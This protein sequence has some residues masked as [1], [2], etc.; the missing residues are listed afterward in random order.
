MLTR[1]PLLALLLMS[2]ASCSTPAQFSAHEAVPQLTAQNPEMSTLKFATLPQAAPTSDSVENL[3]NSKEA[4][5]LKTHQWKNRLLLVFAPSANSPAYQRQMQ[6]FEGRQADFKERDLLLVELLTQGTSST[7]GKMLD[8]ADVAKLRARF[9]V[10]PQ[11]FRVILVGKDGTAKRRDSNPIQPEI[12]F[13]EID[14]M[15]MRQRE[16]RERSAR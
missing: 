6:L 4:F 15:P 1:C 14:A 2:T 10:A 13:R 5:D 3:G 12:I 8:Q 11:D 9:R 7:A 16:M